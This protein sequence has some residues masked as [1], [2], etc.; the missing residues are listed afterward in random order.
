MARREAISPADSLIRTLHPWVAF[1]IMPVFAL[2][3]AGV[4]V[5]VDA[6]DAASW[7][8]IAGVAVGLIVGKPIGVLLACSLALGS[9]LA[10]LPRGISARHLVVLG[11]VAGV[12]FT[13]AL[14]IAQLAFVDAKL[15]AASKLGILAASGGAAVIGL[16]L[17]RL[18]LSPAEI[19]GAA[20]TADEAEG[21]TEL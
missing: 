8:V 16:A 4:T 18:L 11:V 19:H 10:T 7:R 2:A 1:G 17:G 12:G 3:N 14:F 15:L 20:R 5:S 21:S 6:V 9:G 13:M